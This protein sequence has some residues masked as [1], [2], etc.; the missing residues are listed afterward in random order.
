MPELRKHTRAP[1]GGS[2][3]GMPLKLSMSPL[4]E[5]TTVPFLIVTDGESD[6]LLLRAG[7]A[8][9]VAKKHD[10]SGTNNMV[11]FNGILKAQMDQQAIE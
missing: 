3:N 7:T 2:A 10:R 9:A 11:V 1:V 6:N 4:L 5:P 8:E